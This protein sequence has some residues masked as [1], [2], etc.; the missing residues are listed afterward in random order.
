MTGKT[1]TIELD[2]RNT[3]ED[4]KYK[5]KDKEGIPVDLQTL[6]FEGTL[7]LDP[8]TIEKYGIERG[9]LFHLVL[10]LR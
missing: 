4:L 2:S 10:R 5:I 9:S 3:I 1:I 6:V 7:L 8:I